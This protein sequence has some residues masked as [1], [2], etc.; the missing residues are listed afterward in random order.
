MN[1]SN[2]AAGSTQRCSVW[3]FCLF[4]CDIATAFLQ[5]GGLWRNLSR[6]GKRIFHTFTGLGIRYANSHSKSDLS[7]SIFNITPQFPRPL[8]LPLRQDSHIYTFFYPP[9]PPVFFSPWLGSNSPKR[10]I[11][12]AHWCSNTV[13]LEGPRHCHCSCYPHRW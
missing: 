8:S 5:T 6:A 11:E 10:R 1:I 13:Q 12:S 9:L 3:A 7:L 4:R 2:P